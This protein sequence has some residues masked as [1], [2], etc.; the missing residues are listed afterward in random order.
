MKKTVLFLIL[1]FGFVTANAQTL[2]GNSINGSFGEELSFDIAIKDNGDRLIF[3]SPNYPNNN[4]GIVKEYSRGNNNWYL[5]NVIDNDPVEASRFGTSLSISN[6]GNRVAVGA[7]FSGFFQPFGIG[8]VYVYDYN[9]A[10]SEW[11]QVGNVIEGINTTD[12]FGGKVSLSADGNRLAISGYLADVNGITNSGLVRVFQFNSSNSQWEQM[13]NDFYDNE[14]GKDFGYRSCVLSKD[15]STLVIGI[16]GKS[17]NQGETIVYRWYESGSF[18]GQV[19]ATLMGD[20]T[21][22]RFGSSVVVNHDGTLLTIGSVSASV[23]NVNNV[24]RVRTFRL[25]SGSWVEFS[26][27]LYGENESNYFGGNLAMSDDG[28]VLAVA[29]VGW[30]SSQGRVYVYSLVGNEWVQKTSFNGTS[31]SR[32]GDALSLTS[33][34]NRIALGSKP[35]GG[36]RVMLYDIANVLNANQFVTENTKIYPNPAKENISVSLNSSLEFINSRIYNAMGQL[37]TESNSKV[38]NVQHLSKGLYFIEVQTNK[39]KGVQK[40]IKE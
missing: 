2:I 14:S 5:T 17:S 35:N 10:T 37:V 22:E 29:A 27:S 34:G 36:Y 8:K 40:F 13:G 31:H 28:T 25:V 6:N 12:L 3:G 23:N 18:W 11:Q 32:L 4:N 30:E 26:T 38:I 39:G 1:N 16:P 21:T 24:G 20:N 33:D 19:G 9:V 7:P 15:G